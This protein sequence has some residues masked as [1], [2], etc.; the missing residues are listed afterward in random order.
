MPRDSP[1]PGAPGAEPRFGESPFRTKGLL[2]MGTQ[3]F[4]AEHLRGGVDELY[5]DIEEPELRAFISQRF[6]TSGWYDVLPVPALIAYEARALR[7]ALPQYLRHRTKWQAERD[8]KTVHRWV[9]RLASPAM[10]ATRLPRVMMQTFDFVECDVTRPGATEVAV[11]MGGV[12]AVL[13]EWLTNALSV[14]AETALKLAGAHGVE[15]NMTASTPTARR[16]GVEVSR[17]SLHIHWDE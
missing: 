3:T 8:I 14:Y 4:F 9:L 16:A 17:M 13:E 1:P 7:M 2:Y 12:P 5:G 11:Q 15:T 6:L 10:V